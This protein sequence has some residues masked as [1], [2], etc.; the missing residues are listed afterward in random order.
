MDRA[1]RRKETFRVI[2]N[3]KKKIKS[4]HGFDVDDENFPSCTGQ[5]KN[6]NEMNRYNTS[7]SGLY[8]DKVNWRKRKMPYRCKGGYGPAEKC[9][10][11]DA[12]QLEDM[13]RQEEEWRNE[14]NI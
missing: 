14:D 8:K 13:N 2:E 12:T 3:R 6:N 7:H 4:W 5:L 10:K 9:N 1:E 11:H